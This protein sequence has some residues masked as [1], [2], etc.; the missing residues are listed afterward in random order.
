MR[1]GSEKSVRRLWGTANGKTGPSC[2][3]IVAVF[4]EDSIVSGSLSLPLPPVQDVLSVAVAANRRHQSHWL[5]NHSLPISPLLWRQLL[6]PVSQICSSVCSASKDIYLHTVTTT[7]KQLR[8][9]VQTGRDKR[10]QEFRRHF[11]RTK[12]HS[13]WICRCPAFY[14]PLTV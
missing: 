6:E 4:S 11:A 14:I 9:Q 1:G 5:R 10:T 13:C 12:K 2:P 7:H 8:T 3:A